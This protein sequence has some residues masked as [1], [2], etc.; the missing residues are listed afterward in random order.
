MDV[1]CAVIPRRNISGHVS[2]LECHAR[3]SE[4]ESVSGTITNYA[5]VRIQI[6]L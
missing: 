5:R 1:L 6:E 4:T 2:N 3:A